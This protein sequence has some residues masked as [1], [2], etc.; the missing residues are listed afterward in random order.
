MSFRDG[1][2]RSLSGTVTLLGQRELTP[3]SLSLSRRRCIFTLPLGVIGKIC[4]VT[5]S[6][7]GHDPYYF[8]DH[9]I[10]SN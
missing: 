7:S 9:G 6:L 4:S 1:V 3:F 8:S 5:V 10:S 2:W